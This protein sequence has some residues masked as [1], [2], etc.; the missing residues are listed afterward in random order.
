M[1]LNKFFRQLYNY[2]YQYNKNKDNGELDQNKWIT[3]PCMQGIEQP[4]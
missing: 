3:P 4:S 1:G 2:Y